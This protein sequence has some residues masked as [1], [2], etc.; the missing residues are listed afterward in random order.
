[1]TNQDKPKIETSDK[2]SFREIILSGGA[3]AFAAF[4][5]TIISVLAQLVSTK[6]LLSEIPEQYILFATIF[7][8][9]VTIIPISLQAVT[10]Y[11]KIQTLQTERAIARLREKEA[12]FF[13]DIESSWNDLT[14]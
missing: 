14:G 7:I 11:Y 6:S 1:M 2:K 3:T 10:R 8:S 13:S 9:L 4:V 5:T 12:K